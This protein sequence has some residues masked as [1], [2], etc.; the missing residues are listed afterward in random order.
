MGSEL[1]FKGFH[2]N[3]KN[4]ILNVPPKADF[5]SKV[6]PPEKQSFPFFQKL[7]GER[8]NYFPLKTWLLDI[9]NVKNCANYFHIFLSARTVFVFAYFYIG[10]EN[11]WKSKKYLVQVRKVQWGS[12]GNRLEP[13]IESP[14]SLPK[15]LKRSEELMTYF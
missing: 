12:I 1:K 3:A 7:T 5:V 15:S 8:E 9:W 11:N 14:F 6:P 13:K 10:L 2:E 4:T